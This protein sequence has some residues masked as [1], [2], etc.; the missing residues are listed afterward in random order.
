[1]VAPD[2]TTSRALPLAD[3]IVGAALAAAIGAATYVAVEDF[4]EE[5]SPGGCYTPIK[6]ALLASFLVASPWWISSAVGFS[7]TS[8]C[9][10]L[11]R[12]RTR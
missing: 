8:D 4:N 12:A 10:E 11:S 2:C 5:C 3:L 6:P 1:M 9:R 7:D